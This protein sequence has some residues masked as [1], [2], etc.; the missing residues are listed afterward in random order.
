MRSHI[1]PCT[2]LFSFCFFYFIFLFYFIYDDVI[3][4][5]FYV[6]RETLY[7][8]IFLNNEC[9]WKQKLEFSIEFRLEFGARPITRYSSLSSSL[10]SFICFSSFKTLGLHHLHQQP[11]IKS[12]ELNHQPPISLHP[13]PSRPTQ[14]TNSPSHPIPKTQPALAEPNS[15]TTEPIN[16][17]AE[18]NP[19][20]IS[21]IQTPYKPFFHLFPFIN[22]ELPLFHK[23]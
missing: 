2:S 5:M 18:P 23:S 21:H 11:A 19:R 4:L 7:C 8:L 20:P 9:E 15:T 10:I 16:A 13:Y 12:L 3:K 14:N 6:M 22:V 1:I 17:L